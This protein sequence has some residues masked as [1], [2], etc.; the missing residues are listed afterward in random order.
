[1]FKVPN[2]YLMPPYILDE[3]LDW[4]SLIADGLMAIALEKNFRYSR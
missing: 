1:M 2:R 3:I 4:N